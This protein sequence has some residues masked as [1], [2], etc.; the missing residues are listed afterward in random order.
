M[1]INYYAG[2]IATYIGIVVALGGALAPIIAETDWTETVGILTGTVAA[3]TVLREY[4]IGA[5]KHEAR[6]ADPSNNITE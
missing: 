6:I 3:I 5:Q 1:G 4:I 2:R